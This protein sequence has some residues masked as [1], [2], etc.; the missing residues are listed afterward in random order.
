MQ[1][2]LA[3][4]NE[5]AG[6]YSLEQVNHMLAAE[7]VVLTDLAWHEGMDNWQPMAQLTGGRLYYAPNQASPFNTAPPMSSNDHRIAQ[8]TH[9]ATQ[10]KVASAPLA[11]LG[12]RIL[13]AVIDNVL[14]LV[15]LSPVLTHLD[16]DRLESSGSLSGMEALMTNVPEMNVIMAMLLLLG[17]AIAQTAL[18]IKRGQS[19]GKLIVGTR[20]VDQAS[21]IR[22]NA[23]NTFVLRSF[24]I[25][26]LYNLPFIGMIVMIADLAMLLF[27]PERISLHDRLAKTLVVEARPEQLPK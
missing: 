17:I 5:Q 10:G 13:G 26:L 22:P 19:I 23:M 27:S 24:V 8:T 20:I 11:S 12:Q 14:T 3:R 25:G 21:G 18:I 6:P 9:L 7:Q 16:L 4:N 1:I 15:A 2:Y